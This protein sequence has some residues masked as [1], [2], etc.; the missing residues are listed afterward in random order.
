MWNCRKFIAIIANC[1]LSKVSS[2]ATDRCNAIDS[3]GV[4][5]KDG[6][7]RDMSSLGGCT[8]DTAI[9]ITSLE[10]TEI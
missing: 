4:T 1:Y 3:Q 6:G 7:N 10:P 5:P 9:S 2:Y 8:S